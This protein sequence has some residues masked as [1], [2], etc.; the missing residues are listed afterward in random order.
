[1]DH[2]LPKTRGRP[3]GTPNGT[4]TTLVSCYSKHLDLRCLL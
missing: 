1:L 3:P 4:P 2:L